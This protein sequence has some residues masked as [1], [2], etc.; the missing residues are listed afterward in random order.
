MEKTPEKLVEKIKQD[1]LAYLE[2]KIE[3]FKLST[4]ERTGK[5][6]GVLSY[7]LILVFTA[8]FAFLF[9]F[10]SLGFFLGEIFRSQGAG[11][12][13]VA[14]IYLIFIFILILNKKRI[15]TAVE[16]V[17]ISSL[18]LNDDK[19]NIADNNDPKDDEQ[20]QTP[21]SDRKASN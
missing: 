20:Q 4:Y 19:N 7:G 18:M 16:N 11:F 17:V 6:F 8:F 5:V 10:L 12:I 21:D 15:T 9:V 2:L 1:V 13:S 3:F 14:L